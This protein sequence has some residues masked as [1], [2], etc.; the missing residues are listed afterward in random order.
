MSTAALLTVLAL[1]G[2]A[3]AEEIARDAA[4]QAGCAVAQQAVA[5]AED[6]VRQVAK[7]IGANP[8]AAEREL[9]ALAGV[10]DGAAQQLEGEA[11]TQVQRAREA[12]DGLLVEARQAADGTR[13]DEVAVEEGQRELDRALEALATVC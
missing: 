12:V 6:R 5:D 3:E 9:R 13:V 11:Q 10:L 1:P 4:G 7:D 8:Q 2:C